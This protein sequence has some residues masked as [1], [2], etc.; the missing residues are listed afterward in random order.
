MSPLLSPHVVHSAPL[1]SLLAR[2]L[3]PRSDS[4]SSLARLLARTLSHH[5][6]IGVSSN[7]SILSN[8]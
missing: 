5:H 6:V 7:A 8:I 2:L 3:S 1:A 4:R